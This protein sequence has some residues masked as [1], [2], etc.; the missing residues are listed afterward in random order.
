M[1]D[2]ATADARRLADEYNLRF[3]DLT[4]TAIA[5]G[6]A[7]LLPEEIARQYC[8]VPIGRRLGTPVIALAQ[9]DDL[10]TMD[11][12]RVSLGREFVAV[13][14]RADQIMR[15][16]DKIYA[17]AD[18]ERRSADPTPESSWSGTDD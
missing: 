8:A 16:I 6:A 13:V 2:T 10:Y 9:P 15:V 18:Q 17:E 4:Q 5:P 11:T 12:L 7:Q 14:A 3:V 1:T